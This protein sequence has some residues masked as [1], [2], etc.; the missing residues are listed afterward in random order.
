M[1]NILKYMSSVPPFPKTQDPLQNR[2]QTPQFIDQ[3]KKYLEDRYK[4]FMSTVIREHLRDAQR[5]GIPST[6]NLVNAYVGFRFGNQGS[7]SL[8]G[9][10]DGY[11]DGKPLWPLVYYALRCGDIQSALKCMEMAG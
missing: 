3:A 5:G 7:N 6:Y 8:L 2:H 10:Q 4:E 9:L 11:V 1:W